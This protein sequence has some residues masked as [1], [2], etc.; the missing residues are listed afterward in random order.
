LNDAMPGIE[1]RARGFIK[2]FA[3]IDAIKDA[4]AG[5][6]SYQSA[7]QLNIKGQ[8]ALAQIDKAAAE[9]RN[10]FEGEHSLPAGIAN[11][12]GKRI[13]DQLIGAKKSYETSVQRFAKEAVIS[14]A[15]GAAIREFEAEKKEEKDASIDLRGYEF[16]H[17]FTS[18]SGEDYRLDSVTED[19]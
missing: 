18:P 16:G 17:K 12:F 19:G 5:M 4:T 7:G 11:R 14:A 10:P 9:F 13:E 8:A 3:T 6:K 2:Y 1:A 15:N